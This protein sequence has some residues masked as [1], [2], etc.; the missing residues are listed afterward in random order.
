VH[1]LV[2][3]VIDELKGVAEDEGFGEEFSFRQVND[4]GYLVSSAK[5]NKVVA[6]GV[7]NIEDDE[8]QKQKIVGAFAINVQKYSWAEA[9]GFTHQQMIDDLQDLIFKLIG[10]DEVIDY[11]T[12]ENYEA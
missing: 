12:I 2:D 6:I 4:E 5:T 9:E 10:I 3:E 7:I 11:L 8:G 1:P